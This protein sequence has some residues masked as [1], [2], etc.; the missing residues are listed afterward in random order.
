MVFTFGKYAGYPLC[1]IPASYLGMALETFTIPEPLAHQCRAELLHRFGLMQPLPS[2]TEVTAAPDDKMKAIY[3]KLATKY[4]PDK[5]GST[6]AMQ[7]V[8][9][10][11]QE[12][13]R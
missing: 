6:Q 2:Q 8:N 5:G 12:L 4:H 10:F 1:D 11:Y 7:A 3:R 9:E 13:S